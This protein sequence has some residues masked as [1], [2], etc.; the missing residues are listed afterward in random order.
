MSNLPTKALYLSD[1]RQI[2]GAPAAL[3]KIWGMDACHCVGFLEVFCT[4]VGPT[5]N[6]EREG[7]REIPVCSMI[8][9]VMPHRNTL[10]HPDQA[11]GEARD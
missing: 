1:L 5:D 8:S 2:R 11:D 4:R 6:M 9:K 10:T 3:S 7:K